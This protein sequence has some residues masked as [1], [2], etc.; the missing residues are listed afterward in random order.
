MCILSQLEI[1]IIICLKVKENAN[2]STHSGFSKA[3]FLVVYSEIIL[4]SF[5]HDSDT[6]FNVSTAA[7]QC[8]SQVASA[9]QEHMYQGISWTT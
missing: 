5:T 1:V 8:G 4:T 2:S 7:L 6:Y 9:K 3:E